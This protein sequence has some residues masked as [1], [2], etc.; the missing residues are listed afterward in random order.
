MRS[1]AEAAESSNQFSAETTI[2][3]IAGLLHSMET[4]LDTSAG[5]LEYEYGDMKMFSTFESVGNSK[6]FGIAALA[7]I[8]VELSLKMLIDHHTGADVPRGSKGHDL[9]ALWLKLTAD[10]QQRI[11]DHYAKFSDSGTAEE[12]LGN[13]RYTYVSWRYPGDTR[14]SQAFHPLEPD[15]LRS[16]AWATY[17]VAIAEHRGTDHNG[18]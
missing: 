18:G 2:T 3:Q 5:R 7:P 17:G 16:L 12:A 11:E 4:L 9:L 10:Q 15:V 13:H 8:A 14:L 1:G 6:S